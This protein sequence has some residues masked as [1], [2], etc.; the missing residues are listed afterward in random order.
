MNFIKIAFVFF[1]VTLFLSVLLHMA[2]DPHAGQI[3]ISVGR[4]LKQGHYT[5]RKLD[6]QMS[7]QLLKNYLEMLDFNHLFFT[8]KD[9][10]KFQ[11][12]F[13][14]ALKDD[15]LLGTP[16]PAFEISDLFT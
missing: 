8:Q 3:C 7:Q 10:A 1:A 4:L 2:S 5:K 16:T 6:D 12:K 15:I 11:A 13:G 9:V 14:T